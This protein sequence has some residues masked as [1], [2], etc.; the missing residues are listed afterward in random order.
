MKQVIGIILIVVA[1]YLGYIGITGLQES[2]NAVN[3]LGLELKT[4]DSGAKQTAI[5]ELIG[6]RIALIGGIYL[7]GSK[8]K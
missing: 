5:V 4:E 6:A 3:I 8:K 7:V 2:S 1:V